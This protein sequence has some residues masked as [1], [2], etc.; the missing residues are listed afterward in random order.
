M[1]EVA[2]VIAIPVCDFCSN[3]ADYDA[4][5]IYGRW[6]YVCRTHFVQHTH[7]KVG[8]GWGQRLVLGA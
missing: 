7:M 3:E 4:R 2:E 6:A 1:G 8:T 5:T